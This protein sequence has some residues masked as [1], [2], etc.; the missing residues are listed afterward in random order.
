MK[1]QGAIGVALLISVAFIAGC[2]DNGDI[3]KDPPGYESIYVPMNDLVNSSNEF[4]FDM[5]RQLLNGDDNIFFSPYSITIALGMAYEGARGETASE[6]LDVIELP[7]NDL[8]RRAMV[9]SLQSQLNPGN[10]NYQLSTANAY[11]LRQGEDLNDDYQNT[12]END[13]LA[14]G[15]ELNFAGDASGSA[16]TINEWVE[17]ETNNRIKNLI[18][19][20]MIDPLTYLILTNAIYFKADWKWQF[21]EEATQEHKFYLSDG[22]STYADLMNMCDKDFDLN[23]AENDDVQMLQLP[24]KDEE[25]SMFILLPKTDDISALETDLDWDYFDDLKSDM[26]GEWIDVYLPKFKF[27]LRYEIVPDLSDLGM[28]LAFGSGA[29][30]SGIKESGESDLYI[31]DV[32]HQS[33]VEVNEEGTEAAAA[34]AVVMSKKGG[35]SEPEP[36]EFRA[37]HPFI[38]FIEHKATG[39]ILFMGKVENPN[40]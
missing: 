25:L 13:Y 15:Q 33:F 27:E 35:G 7:E 19:P 34:T 24:Y 1:I 31:S 38:F 20:D 28:H 6:M 23:Y 12:I 4:S 11:W 32:V 18:T 26:Y 10:T 17:A 21:D 14:G 37:D 36:V 16:D 9:R 29:D 30:F 3:E 40:N 39:Q 8:E 5:Y 22:T 2:L